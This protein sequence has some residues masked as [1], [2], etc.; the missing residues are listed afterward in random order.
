L[1]HPPENIDPDHI[2]L[3]QMSYSTSSLIVHIET[4]LRKKGAPQARRDTACG[5]EPH[6]AAPRGDSV[7]F[8]GI[9]FV[10]DDVGSSYADDFLIA[11]HH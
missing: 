8:F 2:T 7:F 11:P 9:V 1:Y 4:G 6:T 10:F 5:V 3:R